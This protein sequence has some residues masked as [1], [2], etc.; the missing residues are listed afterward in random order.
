M[1]GIAK[2]NTTAKKRIERFFGSK[3]NG[4]HPIV[5]FLNFITSDGKDAYVIGGCLRDI[6]LRGSAQFKG[7]IDVVFDG[8]EKDLLS[9]LHIW[10]Y[11]YT[12]TKFGGYRIDIGSFQL[13]IWNIDNTWAF[14]HNLVRPTTPERLLATT[15]LNWDA[16][17][18]RW[19]TRTL[20]CEDLYFKDM[21]DG[22][23]E[24]ILD[25]NPNEIKALLKALNIA[26][27]NHAY[28]FGPRLQKFIH[29]TL[30]KYNVQTNCNIEMCATTVT[31]CP[32]HIYELLK[33]T[34]SILD[35]SC[36]TSSQFEAM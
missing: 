34:E 30:A 8:T 9:R 21:Q 2:D 28:K 18:Y 24:I 35:I 20:L 25:K 4:I 10:G 31:Q 26:T 11:N 15:V 23:L 12:R 33:L 6:T 13:D 3:K 36:C 27:A 32:N 29:E 22:K 14:K 19:R 7:D 17:L 5:V 1:V 16:I